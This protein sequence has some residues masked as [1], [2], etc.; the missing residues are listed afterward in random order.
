MET[1]RLKHINSLLTEII[2][3]HD[4]D[5]LYIVYDCA[6]LFWTLSNLVRLL[7]EQLVPMNNLVAKDDAQY[8][9]YLNLKILRSRDSQQ[10]TQVLCELNEV[11]CALE[12]P[13]GMSFPNPELRMRLKNFFLEELSYLDDYHR[14]N[15]MWLNDWKAFFGKIDRLGKM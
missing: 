10:K 7:P 3:S 8:R 11:I 12:V 15:K 9:Q 4:L 14:E 1:E 6:V 2:D 5:L 13:A